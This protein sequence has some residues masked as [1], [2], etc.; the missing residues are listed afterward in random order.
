[1]EH[2]FNIIDSALQKNIINIIREIG[3]SINDII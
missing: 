3:L 2:A 1:M